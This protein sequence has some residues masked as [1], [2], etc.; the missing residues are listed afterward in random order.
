MVNQ[1][2]IMTFLWFQEYVS[3]SKHY[4]SGAK[5]LILAGLSGMAEKA[6]EKVLLVTAAP[7]GVGKGLRVMSSLKR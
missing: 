2:L 7:K 5:A 4:P 3:A 6:A 1:L